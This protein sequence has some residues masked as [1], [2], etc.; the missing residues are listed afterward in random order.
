MIGAGY[1]KMHGQLRLQAEAPTALTNTEQYYKVAGTF[2]DGHARGFKVA[3]NKLKYTGPDG[4]C[5]QFTGVCDLQVDKACHT[6]F[7][8]YKNGEL[9]TGAQT[10][11]T[12]VSPSKT[13]T[14]AI[15]AII[16]LNQDDELEVYAK[17]DTALTTM[18]IETLNIVCWG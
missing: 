13:G 15:V 11:H 7:S 4:V 3:N 1:I 10:P 8:L 14:I 5:F 9:V 12:F 16:E 18:T 2:G 6:V 17:S